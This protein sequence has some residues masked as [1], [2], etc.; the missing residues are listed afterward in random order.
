MRTSPS[1]LAP[2]GLVSEGALLVCRSCATCFIPRSWPT[3][4]RVE[5]VTRTPAGMRTLVSSRSR[6]AFT[7]AAAWAIANFIVFHFCFGAAWR[8]WLVCECRFA[9]DGGGA[10]PGAPAGCLASQDGGAG[11]GMAATPASLMD[12]AKRW[13][14]EGGLGSALLFLSATHKD[15]CA[16]ETAQN[17]V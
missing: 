1:G 14:E 4:T 6:A 8:L 10:L 2:V 5:S 7:L 3:S 15:D 13:M 17:G 12:F 16:P 9:G 11:A